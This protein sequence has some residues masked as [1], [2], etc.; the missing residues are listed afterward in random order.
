MK[1]L[2]AGAG[3]F[4]G[5]HL[6]KDLLAKGLSVRAVDWKPLEDWWQQ[7]DAAENILLDLKD[8]T[9]CET[10]AQGVSQVFNLACDIGGTSFIGNNKAQCM[11][12]V[13]INTHLLLAARNCQVERYF[14]ASSACVYDAQKQTGA[15][16]VAM[17]EEEAYPAMPDDGYGWEKLFGERM[18]R[19]FSEDFGVP[20][21]V[22]RFNNIYGPLS[23]WTGGRERVPA[24][25]C[26]KAIM[27]KLTGECAI[28]IWGTGEQTRNFTYI[29][30]CIKGIN[31]IM[32][33]ACA[34]PVNLG[35]R[36]KISVNQL[37]SLVEELAQIKLIRRYK[38]DAPTGSNG[39]HGDN[40]KIQSL[41][42]WEP[43][44]P[45]AEG[46]KSTYAWIYD[47][48]IHARR[49]RA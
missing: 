24:A 14:F 33:S 15:Q 30:D 35:T 17:K 6:V 5:G 20:T 37:V 45:L 3:G 40:M 41:L 42:N 49:C 25:I 12:S 27:A 32:A 13:L 48:I 1:V 2:V 31:L 29:D 43:Q 34:D 19:H 36:E 46:L 8:K 11:L 9:N 16:A 28:E 47:Q 18:C 22:A 26:R 38:L 39:L 10:A 21:R 7:H 23:S 4:I 44:T